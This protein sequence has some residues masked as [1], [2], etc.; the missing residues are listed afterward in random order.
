[1]I[2]ENTY[3]SQDSRRAALANHVKSEMTATARSEDPEEPHRQAAAAE[4][5]AVFLQNHGHEDMVASEYL[6]MLMARALCAIGDKNAA[7][8]LVQTNGRPINFPPRFAEIAVNQRVSLPEWR[9][10]FT[11]RAVRPAAFSSLKQHTL[12]ILD[13][14]K[15][16]PAGPA[17]LELAAMRVIQSAITRM[18]D[19]WDT[20]SGRGYL[21]LHGLLPTAAAILSSKP[22]TRRCRMLA[23]EF[24][25]QI[26]DCLK[27]TASH[28]KW[29]SLPTLVKLDLR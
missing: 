8:C 5:V 1:M 19:V 29:V 21:G 22:E 13:I 3:S 12:W 16:L 11:S 14:P 15:L 25:R 27:K 4:A 2:W 24:K 9:A 6:L 10:F 7:Q 23:L 18:A 17:C 26:Y 20:T 28:R